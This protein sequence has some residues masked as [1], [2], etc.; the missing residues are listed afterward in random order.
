V[1][2]TPGMRA[3]A[4]AFEGRTAFIS[5]DAP[6]P[7]GRELRRFVG[8]IVA[9]TP[10]G[11]FVRLLD[12][13]GVDLPPDLSAFKRAEPGTYRLSGLPACVVDPDVVTA[14]MHHDDDGL[15]GTTPPPPLADGEWDGPLKLLV[16]PRNDPSNRD[17][18]PLRARA[19]TGKSV[20]IGVRYLNENDVEVDR[21]QLYGRIRSF[22]D[23]EA[24]IMV[25]DGTMVS[26]PPVPHGFVWAKPG[27]YRLA[28]SDRIIENPD[29]LSRWV[30]HTRS[31]L[32]G[33]RLVTPDEPWDDGEIVA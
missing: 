2:W 1:T 11:V 31:A 17:F 25:D 29:A 16:A 18:D 8:E 13:R 21:K 9:F 28:S 6:G 20:I 33:L 10:R 5:I 27:R 14:W 22:T 30:S 4:A 26:L 12:G 32:D 19:L 3:E 23:K 15:S 24:Q 7:R